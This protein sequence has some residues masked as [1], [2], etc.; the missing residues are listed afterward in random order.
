MRILSPSSVGETTASDA[1]IHYGSQGMIATADML[2]QMGK[3]IDAFSY[4]H[5]GAAS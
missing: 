3:D 4:R 1:M 2:Q 5:Y